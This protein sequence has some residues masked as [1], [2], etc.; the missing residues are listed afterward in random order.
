MKPKLNSIVYTIYDNFISKAKV[1]FLGENSFITSDFR[2]CEVGFEHEYDNYNVTWFKNLEK[3]KKYVMRHFDNEEK[4]KMTWY[5][6]ESKDY[7]ELIYK[8]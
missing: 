6:F 3:A 2:Y 8:E 5:E 7:W 4:R 1:E